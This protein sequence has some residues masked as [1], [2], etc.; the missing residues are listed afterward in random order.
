MAKNIVNLKID[1]TSYSARPYG[2][3]T[4]AAGTAAK[5][6]TCADFS[7]TTGATILVKFTYANSVAS[8]TLNVNSTGAKPIYYRGA[9]LGSSLYYWGAN[10]TVEFYYNGTQWD[11]MDVGNTNSTYANYSFGNGYATC[12]TAEAT[13]AKVATY[14]YYS[15]ATGGIVAVKFTYAVPAN[16]TLNINSKGAKSIYYNNAAITAGVIG[17]GDIAT[18]VYDGTNYVLLAV[19][20]IMT[21]AEKTKLSGI[22]SGATA[23]KGT[24]TSIT[25][26]T[27]LTGASSD[28]AITSSGTINLKNAATG[29]IGGIKVGTVNSSAVTTKTEGSN[30]YPVNIDSNGKGYVALPTWSNNSGTITGI[31]MNG[32]SMGTSG[33]VDL[34][35]VITAHQDISGKVD[36]VSGKGLSTNDYTTTEKNKLAGIAS[37]AEVN[38][39]A[40]ASIQYGND[41]ASVVTAAAKSDVLK[42]S[43]SGIDLTYDAGRILFKHADTST[44]SGSYGPTAN[45][46]G[47]NGATIVVPQITV[48]GYGHVTGV[49]NRTYTSKDTKYTLPAA[50]SS[51][52]GGVKIGSNI[53]VSSGTIS[54]T[55]SNVTSALGYTPPT[56][57]T[58]YGLANLESNGLMSATTYTTMAEDS[59]ISSLSNISFETDPLGDK[60]SVHA[61]QGVTYINYTS[62]E[63]SYSES[64]VVG[65]IDIPTATTAKAGVMSA[66]DKTKLNGIATGANKY[67]LPNA[68]SS[69]LGGVKIGSNISV[70]S[71]T[72]SLSKS[73]VTSALGYTPPTTNTTYSVATASTDG[74]MS[75][76]TAEALSSYSPYTFLYNVDGDVTPG[77][78]KVNV[79]WTQFCDYV[80]YSKN[81]FTENIESHYVDFDIPAATTTTAGVMSAADKQRLDQPFTGLVDGKG[82]TVTMTSTPIDPIVPINEYL[83]LS[84]RALPGISVAFASYN[85][86]AVVA[87]PY[88]YKQAQRCAI[89]LDKSQL[90]TIDY[91]TITWKTSSISG[92]GTP[93]KPE[94]NGYSL[95]Y[96]PGGYQSITFKHTSDYYNISAVGVHPT[97]LGGGYMFTGEWQDANAARTITLNNSDLYVILQA[98]KADNSDIDPKLD[99]LSE[100]GISIT[101]NR[102]D[103]NICRGFVLDNGTQVYPVFKS[104]QNS[105]FNRICYYTNLNGNTTKPQLGDILDCLAAYCHSLQFGYYKIVVQPPSNASEKYGVFDVLVSQDPSYSECK[106]LDVTAMINLNSVSD[107]SDLPFGHIWGQIN[108]EPDMAGAYSFQ[109]MYSNE[110]VYER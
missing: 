76:T 88:L 33:V 84:L 50:T 43:G 90:S 72:I 3:C 99:V 79:H 95:I 85:S 27:G 68:T 1:G 53:S 23:N 30:Y 87:S 13:T 15:L 89:V 40:F 19:D 86:N 24:V 42:L 65:T 92:Y 62:G 93:W 110:W 105:D 28:S 12:A 61:T 47:S 81:D 39:N 18:F 66:A 25:P 20:S 16:A 104:T 10:D 17:A 59:A 36:K 35:T 45:V 54:L 9:A 70:S 41:A 37:R 77:S 101:L 48:D 102:S 74:L 6:V 107:M 51:T 75:K 22:A 80:D 97:K 58:T 21:A 69:T 2:T 26:G 67:I 46:T 100:L 38:Q 31:K 108:T 64:G 5:A 11:L 44:L 78:D 56:T 7:L 60:V 94:Q 96:I 49:T 55:K 8:P 109:S 103:N 82:E 32:S 14:Q 57:N 73:N 4:T 71:G 29:E 106:Y 98:K 34:G 52:L 83:N 91:Q 63:N